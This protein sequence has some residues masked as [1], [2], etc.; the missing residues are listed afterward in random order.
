M[1]L[2]RDLLKGNRIA[3]AR[4]ISWVEERLGGY[5]EIL[6][7]IFPYEGRAYR[8]GITGPPGVGKSTL[9]SKIAKVLTEERNAKVG[10][11]AVDPTSPFS[12]GALLGDRV[13]MSDLRGE[14][15][16]IRSVATRGSMGGLSAATKD[17]SSLFDA[18]GMD[19]IIIETI[20]VGQVELDIADAGDTTIVVLTPE[21]DGIQAMKAGLL[22]IADIIVVN[23][24]DREG[25]EQLVGELEFILSL[26]S[27][28]RWENTIL[29]TEALFDKG[30]KEL[31]FMIIKHQEH[32]KASGE[33]ERRRKRQARLRIEE[34]LEDMLKSHLKRLPVSLEGYVTK[35]YQKEITPA[36]A[37]TSLYEEITQQLLKQSSQSH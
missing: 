11:I 3:L 6:T 28:D 33:F 23:K 16:F 1:E 12:G 30:I 26:R 27:K 17:I 9:V 15:V 7:E 19:Y 36:Q 18:F 35:V 2:I 13:R 24:A 21:G 37:A 29:K 14:D 5:E 31:T 32:L 22:E 20:G 4:A 8:I 10:I 34:I 25:V